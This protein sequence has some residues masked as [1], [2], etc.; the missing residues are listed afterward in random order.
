MK[1]YIEKRGEI[2]GEAVLIGDDYHCL[3][4]DNFIS[5]IISVNKIK[6]KGWKLVERKEK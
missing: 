1:Y 2:I 3:I 6:M 4:Y 5:F